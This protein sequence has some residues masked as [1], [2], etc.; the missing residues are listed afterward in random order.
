MQ[1]K[2]LH[3]PSLHSHV[4]G[5]PNWELD[6]AKGDEEEEE[7]TLTWECKLG[8]STLETGKIQ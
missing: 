1:V 8:T 2:K 4:V 3:E 6:H 7:P 5:T